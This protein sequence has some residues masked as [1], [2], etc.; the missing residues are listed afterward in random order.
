MFTKGAYLFGTCLG[1]QGV[2]ELETP[3]KVCISSVPDTLCSSVFLSP[4]KMVAD[5]APTQTGFLLTLRI[6]A[7]FFPILGSEML[8]KLNPFSSYF[9]PTS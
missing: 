5:G 8:K 6:L 3:S 2:E 7:L 4:L 9:F 1:G